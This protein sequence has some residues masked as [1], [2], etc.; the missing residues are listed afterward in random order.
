ME[1]VDISGAP[2]PVEIFRFRVTV[3]YDVTVKSRLAVE[4]Y[5]SG[6]VSL[7]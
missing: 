4:L 6:L 2:Q 7:T 3:S 1:H 5:G